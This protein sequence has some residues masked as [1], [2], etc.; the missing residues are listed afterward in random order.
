MKKHGLLKVLGV[1][2]LLLVIVSFILTGRSDAKDY[3]GL[4][5]VMFNSLKSLYYFFYMSVF[6][7]TIGGFY[8]E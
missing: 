7:L 4:G 3:V 6:A 8:G 1:I 2:L 5:D